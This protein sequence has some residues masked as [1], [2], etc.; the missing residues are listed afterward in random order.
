MTLASGVSQ[1]VTTIENAADA[2]IYGAEFEFTFLP[3][4]TLEVSGFYNY[5]NASYD[6][7][8]SPTLGD[9]SDFPLANTPENTFSATVRYTLPLPES[10]GVVSRFRATTGGPMSTRG[11][12]PT[13]RS[14][15]PRLTGCSMRASIGATFSVRLW[16]LPCTAGISQTKNITCRV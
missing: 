7:F 4:Q 1:S 6:E 15:S 8:I 16:M 10:V 14:P 13:I 3:T 11:A 12:M 2:T 9:I 5:L